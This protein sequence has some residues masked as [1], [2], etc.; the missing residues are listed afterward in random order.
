MADTL[1]PAQRPS[2][3]AVVTCVSGPEAAIALLLAAKPSQVLSVHV[4]PPP[5]ERGGDG[6][7]P[8]ASRRL[9]SAVGRLR[10]LTTLSLRYIGLLSIPHDVT[11]LPC[12]QVPPPC[13]LP[14]C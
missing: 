1:R 4:V 7:P 11:T 2:G 9:G 10:C 12:L 5:E 3:S 6:L 14:V 8:S 13:P